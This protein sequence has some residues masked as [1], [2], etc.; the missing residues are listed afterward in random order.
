MAE[1]LVQ[2]QRRSPRR[3][4]AWIKTRLPSGEGHAQ[5]KQLLRRHKLSTVCEEARCPNLHECWEGGTATVMLLGDTCTRGCRFCAVKT[6]KQPPAPNQDEP[7]ELAEAISQLGLNY[8]VLTM[9]D[10]DDIADG[11][12]DHVARAVE[13]LAQRVPELLVEV[14][15]SDFQGRPEAIERVVSARPAVFAHNIETTES[16]TPTVRD[17]RCGYTQSLE[18]LRLAGDRAS[19]KTLTK[20]SIM[21]GL[22]ET[23]GDLERTF[24]DLRGVGVEVLTLG[25][26]LRPTKKHLPVVDYVTPERFEA[27]GELARSYG[28]GYVASGPLVRSSYRAGEL[29]LEKR[30]RG[31]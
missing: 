10:R 13:G 12:A 6:A 31:A 3:L 8:V 25:Q 30:L 21:L 18:V 26:Y 11:G 27:L 5:L 28:F 29:Y 24:G 14:L 22:G 4:P 1:E 17:P 16:L 15:V 9:V 2:L 20:T 19:E 23:Q 7:E